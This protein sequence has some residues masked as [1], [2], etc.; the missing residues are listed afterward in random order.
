MT[1]QQ[2]ECFFN[3]KCTAEEARQVAEFL[4][5][6]PSL[7]DKYL[8]KAEWNEIEVKEIMPE[9]FWDEVWQSIQKKK[10]KKTVVY[11]LKRT[12]VA[13]SV[14]SIAGIGF[15][16]FSNSEKTNNNFHQQLANVAYKI[17]TNNSK[18]IMQVNLADSSIIRLSPQAVIRYDVPFVNNKR[19][20]YLK[21]EAFFKVAKDSAKPFTVYAGRLATTALG[22]EFKI[23]SINNNVTV[24]L[25]KGKVIIQSTDNF[26]KGW[27]KNIYLKPG[28]QMQYDA[29]NMQVAVEKINA[30]KSIGLTKK[31]AS[32]KKKNETAANNQLNF[33]GA[34]LPQVMKKLAEYYHK[35]IQFDSAEI[36]DK[37][38]TGIINKTDSLQIVLK[39]IG[40]MN[41][42]KILQ[43]ADTFVIQNQKI[44]LP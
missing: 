3:K 33:N 26:L 1:E 41:N 42:L 21:G 36:K 15:Y 11:W 24:K 37:N 5:L 20:I 14:I 13:A 44:K 40:Q 22:T 30:N 25:F 34:S 9:E 4:K 17:V 43:V 23:T 12:A 8:N 39:I 10:N 16:Y 29:D 19:E 18:K 32:V 31:I 28:E 6:N 7:L 38:F 35:K 2:I 27:N